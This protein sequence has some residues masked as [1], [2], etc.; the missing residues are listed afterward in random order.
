M[1]KILIVEDDVKIS[2]I[3]KLQLERIGHEVILENDGIN[4]VNNIN[5][6]RDYY[7]LVL[8][9]LGL[10]GMEGDLVCRN[11]KKISDV[12]IIVLSARHS[13]EEKVELLK[14]GARD[15]VT[16]PF[17]MQE[18]SA[19][20]DVNIRKEKV[21]EI[22][23]KNIV[24]NTENFSLTLEGKPVFL[25]KTEYELVKFLLENKEQIV[26]RDKIVEKIWGWEASDNLLDTTIKN[27]RQKLGKETIK[28]VRRVGYVLK[29]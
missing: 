15:Y 12:P 27:I 24:L 19:R 21:K 8:L 13:V 2:R 26:S 1:G 25:T 7:D 11:I 9:D 22:I 6:N 23:Y 14:S 28:T 16:K 3:L 29:I 5:R 10:P 18:L 20:I 4:A 17:D